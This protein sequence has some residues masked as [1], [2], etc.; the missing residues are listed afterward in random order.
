[1]GLEIKNQKEKSKKKP[2]PRLKDDNTRTTIFLD[3][4]KHAALKLVAAQRGVYMTEII[5]EGIDM[6]LNKYK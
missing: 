3:A 2:G 5:D 4:S 6:V 1:M